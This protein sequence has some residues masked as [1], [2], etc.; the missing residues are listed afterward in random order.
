[1]IVAYHKYGID[2]CSWYRIKQLMDNLGDIKTVK[3]DVDKQTEREI[4]SAIKEADVF[5]LRSSSPNVTTFIKELRNAYPD[6]KIIFDTDDDLFNVS[7][8]SDAY[9]FSG[10]TEVKQKDGKPL[11]VEDE[12]FDP[13]SN[14]KALID[15]EYCLTKADIVTVTTVRLAETIKP[16]NK[17]VVVIPNAINFNIF[18]KLDIVKDDK[19]R[20]LWSGGS[21]HYIDMYNV[22]ADLEKLMKEY[23]NLHLYIIGNPFEGITKDMDQERVHK[24]GWITTDGHGYRLASLNADIAFC[25]LEDNEFNKNKSSIKYY[26]VSAL[27]IPCVCKNMLP[28]LADVKHND[29]GLLYTND[30]YKQVKYLIDNPAERKRIGE[31]AYKYVKKNR[32]VKEIAKDLVALITGLCTKD[33]FVD[34]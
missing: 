17:N 3:I 10:T 15:Y 21:S 14:R 18:P 32:E 24:D 16:L 25:P 27:G 8:Y 2:G 20:L 19:I 33:N 1:M 28:Y 4:M 5:Y 30:F 12:H 23:P 11:W 31:N 29:N 7:P 22:K 6:K 13:Y 26:E 9:A 34:L